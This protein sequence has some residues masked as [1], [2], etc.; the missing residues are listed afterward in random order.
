MFVFVQ[1]FLPLAHVAHFPLFSSLPLPPSPALVILLLYVARELLPPAAEPCPHLA[2]LP[3][4]Q[5]VRAG[6]RAELCAR[7]EISPVLQHRHVGMGTS[8]QYLILA[9]PRVSEAEVDRDVVT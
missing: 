3:L 5:F 7:E 6:A 4:V 8:L 2:Q 9:E 1:S